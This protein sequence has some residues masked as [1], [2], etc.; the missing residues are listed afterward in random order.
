MLTEI[1]V[2]SIADVIPERYKK[3]CLWRALSVLFFTV[4]LLGMALSFSYFVWQ[5]QLYWLYPISWIVSATIFISAFIVGH[6]CGHQSFLKSQRAMDILGHFLL[7]PTLFPYFSWKESHNAHHRYTNQLNYG[8]KDIYFDN[9]WVPLTKHKLLEMK[10]RHP[11]FAWGYII[12]FIFIPIGSL[13]HLLLKHYDVSKYKIACRDR[14]IFSIGF[15]I[16]SLL[17][18]ATWIYSITG[19]IF[20]I[21]HL[22]IIP[23]LLGQFWMSLYTYLHHTNEET[24]LYEKKEWSPDKTYFLGTIYCRFS[25]LISFIHFNINVHIPHHITVKVPCY[26][27]RQAN[28]ALRQSKFGPYMRTVDF[29]FSYL[30]RQIKSCLVWDSKRNKYLSFSK[31]MKLMLAK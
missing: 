12:C 22:W 5:Q 4:I 10:K 20:L 29:S 21:F 11:W 16:V 18:V 27:L 23:G 24:K 19:S 13:L 17:L 3:P 28:K 30:F 2:K 31:V 7:L 14:V 9:A 8:A 6:D 25:R 15:V 26:F 1:N